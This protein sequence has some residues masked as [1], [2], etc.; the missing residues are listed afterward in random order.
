MHTPPIGA[1]RA[2][3][4][5]MDG[6]LADS[7]E[8]HWEAW[9]E[10]MAATGRTLTRAQ[11]S[12]AF[13]QRNESFLREWLGAE[14]SAEAIARFGDDK[15]AVYRRRVAADGLSALPGAVARATRLHAAGWRQAV[16][17]SAPR[18]N[19]QVMLRAIGLDSVIDTIVGAEDV[20]QGKPA[21]D[22]FLAAARAVDVPPQRCI[23]V[24]DAAVGVEAARRAGMRSIGVNASA[25][26]TAD[27]AVASLDDL[28]PDA[29]DR[30]L[31]Q[32]AGG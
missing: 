6:T 9:R 30:L 8:Q 25:R 22:V 7:G 2:V 32:P 4:W 15:E 29:F 27:V 10:A 14:L 23:V 13:G 20:V 3:L 19:V 31:L 24:E 12:A 26:L 18:A 16:A 28:A 1:P 5:D 21:P 17:S 11:F